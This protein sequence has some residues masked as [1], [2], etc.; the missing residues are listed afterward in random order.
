MRNKFAVVCLCIT[1][2]LALLITTTAAGKMVIKMD[3]QAHTPTETTEPT[4]E[5]PNPI[6]AIRDIADEYEQLYPDIEIDFIKVP[7][8]QGREAWLQARM[9][10]KDAPDV[11]WLNFDW[12]WS[13][14]HKGW[15]KDLTPYLERPNKYVEGN[16]AWQDMFVD[17]ILDAVRAPDGRIYVI[18]ADGVGVGIYYNKTIFAEVGVE[19]PTTWSEFLAIQEKIKDAGYIPFVIQAG[20]QNVYMHWVD[21]I[22][23]SQLIHDKIDKWDTNGNGFL[24][25]PEICLAIDEGTFPDVDTMKNMWHLVKEWSQYWPKGFTSDID[26]LQTFAAGQGAMMLEGSWAVQMLKGLDPDFEV[27]V[28]QVPV[29]TKDLVPEASEVPIRIYGPWGPAQWIIPGY[30]P[31]N[32]VEATIDWLMY[33]SRPDNIAEMANDHGGAIPNISMAADAVSPELSGFMEEIPT[34]VIQGF[35]GVIDKTFEDRYYSVIQ[36]YLS[37]SMDMDQFAEQS[38]RYYKEG[39]KRMLRLNPEW[40]E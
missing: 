16:T 10:A 35:G 18:P 9:M 13:H 25:I 12:T 21:G 27:G 7:E 28:F 30:L 32:R 37:G 2:V 15:F 4:K 5:V 34:Q 24:D 39:A 20:P 3:A 23:Q 17:G 33:L 26:I 36:L 8:A 11:F 29:I 6:R 38:L 19:P 31:E 40:K 22:L 1:L 14:Y